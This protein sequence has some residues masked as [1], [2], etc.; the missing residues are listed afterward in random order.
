MVEKAEAPSSVA[1][2]SHRIAY[3]AG[4]RQPNKVSK[5]RERTS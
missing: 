1:E 5:D 2:A 3:I 4:V